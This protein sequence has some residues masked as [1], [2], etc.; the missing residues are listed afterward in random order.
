MILASKVQINN[1]LNTKFM[2]KMNLNLVYPNE[3]NL[4]QR[5]R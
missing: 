5:D 4:G 2:N 3:W 1:A